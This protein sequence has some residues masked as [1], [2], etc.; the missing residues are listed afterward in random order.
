MGSEV[1]VTILT[2]HTF[3]GAVRTATAQSTASVPFISRLIATVFWRGTMKAIEIGAGISR[4]AVSI[5]TREDLQF[6]G[7]PRS[8]M[9]AALVRS[10]AAHSIL[11]IECD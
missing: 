9:A 8:A 2:A 10:A 1:R 6:F 11:S 7:R 3:S 5:G 4:A